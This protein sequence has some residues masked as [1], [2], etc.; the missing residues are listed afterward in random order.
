MVKKK[1]ERNA[2]FLIYFGIVL[3]I[4]FIRENRLNIF[5]EEEGG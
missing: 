1:A 4:F 5:L 2:I 3:N